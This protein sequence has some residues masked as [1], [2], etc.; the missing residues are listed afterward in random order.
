MPPYV[1]RVTISMLPDVALLEIFDFYVHGRWEGPNAWHKLVHVC[2]KWRNIAFG[3]PGRLGLQLHCT[4]GTPV[5]KTLDV[6]PPLPIVIDVIAS[7]FWLPIGKVDTDYVTENI[8]AALKHNNR[9]CQLSLSSIPLEEVLATMQQPFPALT[10][11][12]LRRH[13][14]EVAP[15]DADSFLGG[16]A[17]HLQTLKLSEIPIPGLPKLLLSATH[18]VLLELWNIPHSGHI[19]PEAMVTGLSV[20]TR[21]ENLVIDF[22][23]PRSRP[24]R[25]R[26]PPRTRALLPVLTELWFNGVTEYLEDVVARIDAP[27]LDNLNITFFHQ[28]L[29]DTPHLAQFISRTP[30]FSAYDEAIVVFPS[31]DVSVKTVDERLRLKIL[32]KQPD[33]QLSSLAQVCRASFPQTLISTME[34]LYIMSEYYRPIGL[35]DAEPSFPGENHIESAQWLELLHQFAAVKYL[36]ISP[37]C[38]PS[39]ATA[40]Q[41]LVAEAVTEVLPALQTLLLKELP[42]KPIQEAIEKFVSARQLSNHPITVSRWER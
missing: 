30:K 37:V 39:I 35:E 3:S 28:L 1:P 32:C 36:Y 40:L 15:I 18:L 11:L 13:E 42:S 7:S 38:T 31:W 5:M 14:H 33:W 20:L 16:S 2:Q 25:R 17:P 24:D 41:E 34:T 22:K 10:L 8:I 29:F 6:W 4:A 21:L 12:H 19:S 23:S 27:L 26:P 9:V